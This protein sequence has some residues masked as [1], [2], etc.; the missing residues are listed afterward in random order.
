M[1]AYRG[2]WGIAPLILNLGAIRRWV[3]DSMTRSLCPWERTEVQIEWRLGG[4]QSRSGRF[5][6]D[7]YLLT[8]SGFESQ[9]LSL[10]LTSSVIGL[11]SRQQFAFHTRKKQSK[12]PVKE[13]S[14]HQTAHVRTG[15][16]GWWIIFF[17][18]NHEVPRTVKGKGKGR[19][20]NQSHYSPGQ[21]LRVPG[22][23]GSQ[24]SRQSTDEDGKV[25]SPTHRPLLSPGNI[26]G[27]Y[28]C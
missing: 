4:S 22:G 16:V 8:V 6:Q 27:T 18:I 21:A 20:V 24:I 1:K 12:S 26:L 19:K 10:P 23:W 25:V 28:F 2:F 14:Y 13:P 7:R 15:H 9:T 17:C 5:G 11:P 3:A